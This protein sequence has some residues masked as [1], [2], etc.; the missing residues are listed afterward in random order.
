M[1]LLSY[2]RSKLQLQF[3]NPKFFSTCKCGWRSHAQLQENNNNIKIKIKMESVVI[4]KLIVIFKGDDQGAITWSCR[5]PAY[6]DHE[7]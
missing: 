5:S 2:S 4:L 6:V 7:C 3:A 1:E